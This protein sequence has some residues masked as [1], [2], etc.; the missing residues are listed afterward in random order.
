MKMITL[1]HEEAAALMDAQGT[2][3]GDSGSW[4]WGTTQQYVINRDGVMY[5]F[6]MRSHV[7]E[8]LQDEGSVTAKEVN[9]IVVT[10][11]Y[12]KPAQ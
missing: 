12:W 9:P 2:I 11:T 5:A 4:R 1:T 10:K 7:E 3:E 8:G 6:T